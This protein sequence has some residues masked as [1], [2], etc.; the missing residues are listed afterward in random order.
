MLKSVHFKNTVSRPSFQ[1]KTMTIFN[2]TSAD[3][4]LMSADV[5]VENGHTF[6]WNEGRVTVFLKWT[7]FNG[8]SL[9]MALIW[10]TH[11]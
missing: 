5:F 9:D 10:N 8:Y 1:L 3:F 11:F 6:E 7:D 2:K 4:V